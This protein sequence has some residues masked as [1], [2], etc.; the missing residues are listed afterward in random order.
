MADLLTVSV[1]RSMFRYQTL[2]I[3]APRACSKRPCVCILTTFP[4]SS[5]EPGLASSPP[6]ARG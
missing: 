4:S 1:V 2:S 3:R 6:F 5:Y